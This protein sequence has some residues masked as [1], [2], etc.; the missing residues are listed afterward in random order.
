MFDYLYYLFL[1]CPDVSNLVNFVTVALATAAGGEEDMTTDLLS[2][3]RT[4]GS[5]FG[6]LIY[7]LPKNADYN[8]LK[9]LCKTLWVTMESVPSLPDM[10]VI[11]F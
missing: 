1:Y 3:L 6:P 11:L 10:M 5:G 7:R 8:K 4:V 2:Y 9:E